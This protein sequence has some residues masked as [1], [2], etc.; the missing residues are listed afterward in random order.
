LVTLIARIAGTFLIVAAASAI[1]CGGGS[2]GPET[3]DDV[4]QVRAVIQA[5]EK[6]QHEGDW[7]KLYTLFPEKCR[8][9]YSLDEFT[10]RAEE[11]REFYRHLETEVVDISVKGDTARADLIVYYLGEGTENVVEFVREDAQWRLCGPPETECCEA[12]NGPKGPAG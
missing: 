4:T 5:M 2:E 9:R 11:A 12:D 3:P 1:G 10:A 7:Q 6:A 8:E